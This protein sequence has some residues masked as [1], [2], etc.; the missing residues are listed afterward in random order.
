MAHQ[1]VFWGGVA[2]GGANKMEIFFLENVYKLGLKRMVNLLSGYPEHNL[3]G[4]PTDS[5]II[6]CHR[7]IIFLTMF[8]IIPAGIVFIMIASVVMRI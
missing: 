3:S 5:D 6:I 7:S 8:Y 4:Y 1:A 2:V